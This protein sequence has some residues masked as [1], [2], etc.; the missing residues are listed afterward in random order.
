M[1]PSGRIFNQDTKI[2]FYG[3]N[4]VESYMESDLTYDIYN[5]LTYIEESAFEVYNVY[6]RQ[7]HYAAL[8]NNIAILEEG[9][10][11][12]RNAIKT[13]FTTLI[14]KLKDFHNTFIS[15]VKAYVVNFT[16]FL[17]KNEDKIKSLPDKRILYEG[18][19]YTIDYNIPRID[20]IYKI[21]TNYNNQID[22]IDTLTKN[23]IDELVESFNNKFTQ[24]AIQSN[25]IG[26]NLVLKTDS[27]YNEVNKTFRNNKSDPETIIVDK[28]YIVEGLE[29]YKNIY[30]ILNQTTKEYNMVRKCL[31][32]LKST[33]S[34]RPVINKRKSTVTFDKVELTGSYPVKKNYDNYNNIEIYEEYLQYQFKYTKFV[35]NCIV[36]VYMQKLNA[37]KESMRQYE[38]I[39]KL[40]INEKDNIEVKKK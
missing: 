11:D 15:N 21:I 8:E 33:F 6:M 20:I 26:R 29:Q 4:S 7:K 40:Y 14:N 37:I 12:V 24:E 30:K 32:D 38:K 3:L 19:N 18:Y 34:K 25:I 27:F 10:N 23:K 16:K 31:E 35:C 17:E 13:F 9:A 2:N 5:M 1:I 22:N 36:N 28:I 39:L